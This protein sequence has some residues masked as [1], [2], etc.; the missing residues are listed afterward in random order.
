MPTIQPFTWPPKYSCMHVIFVGL[1]I[2]IQDTTRGVITLSTAILMHKVFFF[3]L[4][5]F[6]KL[7]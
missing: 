4:S 7:G 1:V 2:G 5:F 6:W 3:F